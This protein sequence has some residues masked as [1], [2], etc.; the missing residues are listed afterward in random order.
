MMND[1]KRFGGIFE[2]VR[3]ARQINEAQFQIMGNLKEKING[4]LQSLT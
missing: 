2:I 1:E 3:K 4:G